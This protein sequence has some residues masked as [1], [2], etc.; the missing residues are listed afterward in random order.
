MFPG[1]LRYFLFSGVFT[2]PKIIRFHCNTRLSLL[3]LSL[4]YFWFYVSL[5]TVV[6]CLS[7]PLSDFCLF[8]SW[9]DAILHHVPLHIIPSLR[10]LYLCLFY[11]LCLRLMPGQRSLYAVFM[12][13]VCPATLRSVPHKFEQNQLLLFCFVW[14]QDI[15][16]SCITWPGYMYV[17]YPASNTSPPL[18]PARP[19]ARRPSNS[20][21]QR[22]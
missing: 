8:F 1:L 20:S 15:Q 13:H 3:P 10:L 14:V 5:S 22:N 4:S 11:G 12:V 2:V 17:G 16:R 6:L 9:T 21:K 18:C 19:L 7:Y